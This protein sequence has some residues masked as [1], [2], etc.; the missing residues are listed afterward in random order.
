MVTSANTADDD[1]TAN[2]GPYTYA[3]GKRKT[4][5]ALVRLFA[6]GAGKI[7]V[8]DHPVKKYFT[9]GHHLSAFLAPLKVAEVTQK[10][11]D[12]EIKVK[13]G[14]P[15]SQAEAC[16]H[17]LA[18]TLEK[19]DSK[20]RIGLKRAGFLT[21]DSRVKERKKPGLKGARRAPQ[22]SKR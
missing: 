21:R 4:A 12:I 2:K 7:T 9:V 1:N 16:R 11:Y 8:N 13:G 19:E 22:W 14:G 17:G 20:R 15:S 18:K 3:V 10:D 5:I 6:N